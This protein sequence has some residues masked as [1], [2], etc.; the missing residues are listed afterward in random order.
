LCDKQF[1]SK[2][3]LGP[4]IWCT[5]KY[6]DSNDDVAHQ[7]H[8]DVEPDFKESTNSS[9][10]VRVQSFPCKACNKVIGTIRGLKTHE[11]RKH[12][13]WE[14]PLQCGICNTTFN[15]QQRLGKHT[16]NAHSVIISA[17][18]V[19]ITVTLSQCQVFQP[20]ALSSSSN[21]ILFCSAR[22]V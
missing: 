2:Q 8:V 6:L 12:K 3:A 13:M 17:A 15:S 10:N 19:K 18:A 21:Q 5:H 9:H 11:T 1:S 4:H 16:A 7:Q 22:K 14:K 20:Q